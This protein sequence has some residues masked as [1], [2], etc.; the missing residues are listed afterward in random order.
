[1]LDSSITV[2]ALREML[3]GIADSTK[4][5]FKYNPNGP[6]REVMKLEDGETKEVYTLC[7][8][9]FGDDELLEEQE[10]NG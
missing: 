7:V 10:L 5:L 6:A 4:V 9:H 2:G 3:E 1:M 8:L